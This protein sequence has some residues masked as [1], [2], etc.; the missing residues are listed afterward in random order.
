MRKAGYDVLVIQG[1]SAKP[2]Y[3]VIEDDVV[4]IEDAMH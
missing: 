2:V 4:Q 3:I 1:R